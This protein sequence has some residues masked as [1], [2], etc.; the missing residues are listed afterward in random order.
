[1]VNYALTIVDAAGS[2]MRLRGAPARL[3]LPTLCLSGAAPDAGGPKVY[4]LCE[5]RGCSSVG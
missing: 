4:R 1:M 2:G 3:T 5:M